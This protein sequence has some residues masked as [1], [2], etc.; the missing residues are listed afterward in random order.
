[1]KIDRNGD[2]LNVTEIIELATPS[3]ES[4]RVALSSALPG[5]AKRI[6]I[7]FSQTVFVDCGGL[8]ALVAVRNCARSRSREITIRLLNPPQS[9]QRMIAVMR[10]DD[11]FQMEHRTISSIA[12]PTTL[13]D[14]AVRPTEISLTA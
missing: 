9:L 10:M 14:G 3:A 13:I 2:T 11:A 6:D 1:M 4:F 12:V 8:G 5:N 7:D